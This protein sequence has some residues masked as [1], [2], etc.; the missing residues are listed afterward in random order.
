MQRLLRRYRRHKKQSGG[1]CVD[2]KASR[3]C[4]PSEVS[5]DNLPYELKLAILHEITDL[6]SLRALTCASPAYREVY[7]SESHLIQ[8][9]V[10]LN[11]D[12]PDLLLDLRST[13]EVMQ[14]AVD[15]KFHA[16]EI[17]RFVERCKAK[18]KASSFM[19]GFGSWTI[20][21]LVDVDLTVRHAI[22]QYFQF[23]L[24]CHPVT[25]EPLKNNR[26]VSHSEIRRIHRAFYRY[27]LFCII[28]RESDLSIADAWT[29]GDIQMACDLEDL[30]QIKYF[31]FI[32]LFKAW[33]IEGIACI[34]DY[35][36]RRY[37]ALIHSHEQEFQK[38]CF[39][40]VVP[41]LSL[42]TTSR[43]DTET[44][45]KALRLQPRAHQVRA[46]ILGQTIT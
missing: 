8:S 15:D 31:L 7:R 13:A 23:A 9:S 29:R 18:A 10:L 42:D 44:W 22:K 1:S 28:F 39:R 27:E 21:T 37:K 35:I 32:A 20:E 33:E 46:N 3:V 14:V 16:P 45:G 41:W 24:S 12:Y 34:R 38:Q 2:L 17:E 4:I 5:L 26:P 40:K 11:D 43:T 25:G 36:I 6:V 30:L 19:I